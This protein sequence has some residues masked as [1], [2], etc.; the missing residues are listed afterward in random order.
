M[1][2]IRQMRRQMQRV[3]PHATTIQTYRYIIR[4]L[5]LLGHRI[6][7]A[8]APS[9]NEVVLSLRDGCWSHLSGGSPGAPVC[10][11]DGVL[12]A[13]AEGGVGVSHV[14]SA[15]SIEVIVSAF[16]ALEAVLED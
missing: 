11:V 6:V 8:R 2:H 7:S 4:L 16:V 13:G 3:N 5:R 14:L 10:A 15:F 1:R 9:M 12:G